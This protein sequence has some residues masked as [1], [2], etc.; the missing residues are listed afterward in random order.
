MIEIP[1]RE[2]AFKNMNDLKKTTPNILP[3]ESA[4]PLHFHLE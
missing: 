1:T 3:Q 4:L 2:M